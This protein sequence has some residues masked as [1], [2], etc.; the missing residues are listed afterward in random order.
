VRV[1]N[2]KVIVPSL[3][4]N[5]LNEVETFGA[6]AWLWMQSDM[7][8]G[9]PLAALNALLLPAIK[10]G[11]FLLAFEDDK[12]V[13]YQ[14]WAKLNETTEAAYLR[15]SL[16]ITTV[17]DWNS[18]ERYWL[19]DTIVPFGHSKQMRR[20]L[21]HHVLPNECIRSLHHKGSTRG[22]KV[23]QIHGVAVHTKEAEHWFETNPVNGLNE[24]KTD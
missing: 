5:P 10:N 7:H 13:A 12:P 23:I 2:L 22:L 9:L 3:E 8:K 6:A 20:V 4:A 21:T 24:L 17:E 16:G 1:N 18:G 19:T 11:Q 15:S 14:G